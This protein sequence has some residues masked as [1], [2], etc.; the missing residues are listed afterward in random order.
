[1]F[2]SISSSKSKKVILC[3]GLFIFLYASLE[4]FVRD[5]RWAGGFMVVVDHDA[6]SESM[7]EAIEKN[8]LIIIGSSRA[9]ESIRPS[10]LS[11]EYGL[12]V[13][14]SASHSGS[15]LDFTHQ[16]LNRLNQLP[17]SPQLQHLLVTVEPLHFSEKY[18]LMARQHDNEEIQ[19]MDKPVNRNCDFWCM[20]RRLNKATQEMVNKAIS[21]AVYD[22]FQATGPTERRKLHLWLQTIL[23]TSVMVFRHGENPVAAFMDN[24]S[25]YIVGKGNRHFTQVTYRDRGYEGHSLFIADPT[26]S[27]ET[28]FSEHQK[29]Y[30]NWV[31]PSYTQRFHSVFADDLM[32]IKK[33]GIDIVL[34]RLPIYR[35]LYAMEQELVPSFN[36]DMRSV[37]DKA[38]V[39]YVDG[40]K[41][42]PELTGDKLAFTDSSHMEHSVT[43]TFSEKLAVLLKPVIH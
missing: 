6:A 41:M 13:Y 21:D 20:S 24:F 39:V 27:R 3:F 10:V 25:F 38:G 1:M 14:N 32:E 37:A 33:H 34:L 16:I 35:D 17:N 4:I 23:R 7:F 31:L 26:S 22:V 29:T 19:F 9:K 43:G 42:F 30:Q 40:N 8:D 28:A 5:H 18:S 15:S 11:R 36:D 12:T 2:S